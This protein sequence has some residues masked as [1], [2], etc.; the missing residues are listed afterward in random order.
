MTEAP[1][2]ETREYQRFHEFCDACRTFKYIGLCYGPPGVGKTVSAHYYTHGDKAEPVTLRPACE[3]RLERGLISKVILYTPG[4]VNAPGQ[5]AREIGAYRRSLNAALLRR[6]DLEEKPVYA[7]MVQR[8]EER[9]RAEGWTGQEFN[10]RRADAYRRNRDEY[11]AACNEYR[12]RRHGIREATILM[13]IDE[14]D[15]LKMASLEQIR[16]IFDQGA[17]GLV[18]IGMPGLEKRLARYPQLYSRV[19]FVHE[20]SALAETET[21][22]LLLKGW[23]PPGVR[24]PANGLSNEEA[25]AAILRITG[26][27]FRLLDRLLTQ[28]SRV[29]EINELQEVSPAVV[30]AA[31]ESLVIGT[32]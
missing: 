7:V 17:M 24:L 3:G 1:F 26:G 11:D 9:F 31:R 21:R 12:S 2:V 29:L 28:I 13:V 32:Q 20:F 10:A 15:R 23:K 4:V 27:N 30:E 19:G 14:A 8:L 18:L 22:G 6:L 16:A 25:L 5:I